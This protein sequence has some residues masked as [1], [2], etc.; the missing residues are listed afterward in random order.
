MS[1]PMLS[2]LLL[3]ILSASLAH[4]KVFNVLDYGAHLNSPSDSGAAFV[5]AWNA[6]CNHNE[7]KNEV[8]V[9]KGTYMMQHAVLIGPCMAKRIAFLLKGTLK[10]YPGTYGQVDFVTFR[11]IDGL[12]V[13][14]GGTLDGQGQTTWHHNN[15]RTNS[16]CGPFP[17]NLRFDFVTNSLVRDITSLNSKSVHINIF[18]SNRMNLTNIK[19]LAPDESPNTD[20][21]H[22]GMVSRIR[23]TRSTI[24]TGDDCISLSPGSN[25][26]GIH[27]VVCGPGHGISIGSLGGSNGEVV[28]R[29]RV[30]NCTFVNT[31]NGVRVKTWPS[32][33]T[34]RV[35]RLIMENIVMQNVSNPIIIDQQYCPTGAC[36]LQ[37][38][39]NVQV[40]NVLF[41][42]IYGTSRSKVAVTLNCSK[43]NPCKNVQ[44]QDINLNFNGRHDNTG[45]VMECTNVHGVSHGRV[46]PRSCV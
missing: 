28:S 21:I 41:K 46:N 29:V 7:P 13:K 11:Y 20:G 1:T 16:G 19:I 43:S 5:K 6:A 40:Q 26:V 10:A 45:T 36:N 3:L 38:S 17:T 15:C 39:S 24:S 37:V 9:P 25:Q 30:K 31:D 22:M 12:V 42:N 4:C 8:L 23:I 44:L 35:D 14:G 2:A 32:S 18:A 33:K 34:G 27:K